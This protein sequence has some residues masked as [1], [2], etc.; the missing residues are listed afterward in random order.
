MLNFTAANKTYGEASA[1]NPFPLPKNWKFLG[2]VMLIAC[3]RM[4]PHLISKDWVADHETAFLQVDSYSYRDA[5]KDLL[6][7]P[8][9]LNFKHAD[10]NGRTPVYPVFIATVMRICGPNLFWVVLVQNILLATLVIPIYHIIF[11][12]TRKPWISVAGTLAW[13]LDGATFIYANYVYAEPIYICLSVFSIYFFIVYSEKHH[14]SYLLGSGILWGL[15]TLTR[16]IG[17]YAPA[18]FSLILLADLNRPIKRRLLSAMIFLIG[19]GMMILPVLWKRKQTTGQY[20][21]SNHLVIL[22]RELAYSSL[23]YRTK[24][25]AKEAQYL[26]KK[27]VADHGKDID[28]AAKDEIKRHPGACLELFM[29][30][31]ALLMLTPGSRDFCTVMGI[32]SEFSVTTGAY[33]NPSQSSLSDFIRMVRHAGWAKNIYIACYGATLFLIYLFIMIDFWNARGFPLDDKERMRWL[34]LLLTAYYVIII[35]WIGAPR[36][37]APMMPLLIALACLGV[38][39]VSRRHQSHC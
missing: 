28:V 18:I 8:A 35:G 19:F 38:S 5:A 33:E 14:P 27:D 12:L 37:R 30:G 4:T 15:A 24:I 39:R 7:G 26:F 20:L 6:Q 21:L 29:K 22:T 10:L 9:F 23:A 3:F 16:P 13:V 31:V 1:V 11:W 2:W 36:Y 32:P 25:P 17:L 34:L